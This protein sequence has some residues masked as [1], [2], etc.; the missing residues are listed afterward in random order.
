MKE[1]SIE[2]DI[3][4]YLNYMGGMFW[5]SHTGK[6]LP[7]VPGVPD[8]I[9]VKNGKFVAVEVKRPGQKPTV[10]QVAFMARLKA[11]GA[12]VFIATSVAE[13]QE[14]MSGI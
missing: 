2:N 1:A 14:G 4:E 6:N 9:G 12:R 8:I 7:C 3:L 11:C 13:A 10:Q 5:R